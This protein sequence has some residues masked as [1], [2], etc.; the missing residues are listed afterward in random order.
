M[1]GIVE[2]DAGAGYLLSHRGDSSGVRAV[3]KHDAGDSASRSPSAGRIVGVRGRWSAATASEPR[4]RAAASRCWRAD[5]AP[6]SRSALRA[7]CCHDS[8]RGSVDSGD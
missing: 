6:V 1:W 7:G 2:P 8:R 4:G 5:A 3:L